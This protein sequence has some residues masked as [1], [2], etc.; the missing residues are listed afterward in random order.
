MGRGDGMKASN[1]PPEGFG[2]FGRL[3]ADSRR[4]ATSRGL[5][6]LVIIVLIVILLGR[7]DFRLGWPW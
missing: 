5:V 7:I 1:E 2:T 4:V 3:A 6:G